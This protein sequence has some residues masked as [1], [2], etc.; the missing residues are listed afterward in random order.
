MTRFLGFCAVV[1]LFALGAQAHAATR[2][3]SMD[4]D[5]EVLVLLRPGALRL[6]DPHSEFVTSAAS[7]RDASLGSLLAAHSVEA[8][9]RACPDAKPSDARKALPDGRVVESL[10]LSNLFRVRLSRLPC[11]RTRGILPSRPGCQRD[12]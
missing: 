8:I 2:A 12:G 1:F 5:R 6:A 9:G 11:P 4:P 10:D 7:F 3:R